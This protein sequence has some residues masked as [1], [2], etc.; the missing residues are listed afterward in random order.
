MKQNV[1]SDDVSTSGLSPSSENVFVFRRAIHWS[2]RLVMYTL[3]RSYIYFRNLRNSS[4]TIRP[5]RNILQQF[6]ARSCVENGIATRALQFIS[7]KWEL[8]KRI[9]LFVSCRDPQCS[10]GE[11]LKCKQKSGGV[12]KESWRRGKYLKEFSFLADEVFLHLMFTANSLKWVSSWCGRWNWT[13]GNS[14][15]RVIF[16][17]WKKVL[18]EFIIREGRCRGCC[19]NTRLVS[20]IIRYLQCLQCK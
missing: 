2:T 19:W 11:V 15:Q 20:V 18:T 9:F 13:C 5:T 6:L 16:A 10:T 17:V 12:L 3:A 7:L 8:K 14:R 4:P 1:S